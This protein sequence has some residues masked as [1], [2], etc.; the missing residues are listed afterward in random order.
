MIQFLHV[1]CGID[2]LLFAGSNEIFVI[3]TRAA[4]IQIRQLFLRNRLTPRTSEHYAS[5]ALRTS[6]QR[7]GWHWHSSTWVCDSEAWQPIQMSREKS[8][9]V[10]S[11]ASRG[12]D[13]NA[14]FNSANGR[15]PVASAPRS[16]IEGRRGWLRSNDAAE[17]RGAGRQV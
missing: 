17:T 12:V 14:R 7:K 10:A 8:G 15:P 11:A 13:E 16:N 5:L 2:S 9:S 6:A 1:K 4:D 3:N